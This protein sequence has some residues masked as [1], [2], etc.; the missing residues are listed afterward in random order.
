MLRFKSM[1]S[2]S[3]LHRAAVLA[4]VSLT[5]VA[6]QAFADA[7][8]AE[9][10]SHIFYIMMENHSYAEIV[11][12]QAP[13]ITSLANKYNVATQYYGVTHPSLPNYLAAVS[14]DNQGIWDDCK[15]GA[16][17]VC[18]PEEF[19]STATLVDPSLF[20]GDA[21]E[22]SP[23][24]NAQFL[25]SSVTPHLFS[26]TTLFDSLEQSGRS[27]K[28]YVQGVPGAD[29]GNALLNV[30]FYPG[31]VADPTSTTG[32]TLVKL[33][34]QKHAPLFY[35]QDVAASP[36]RLSKIVPYEDLNN[37]ANPGAGFLAD[38]KSGHVPAFSFIVPDQCHDMHGLSTAGTHWL[39]T[40]GHPELANCNVD[41]NAIQLGDAFVQSTVKAIQ[42]SK[43]W[44]QG[45]NYIIIV[46]D[47]DDYAGTSGCCGS[48]VG[49][50]A[51]MGGAQV[52]AIVISNFAGPR[53]TASWPANHYT[54]LGAI[55]TLW[56]L[57]CLG[58]SCS[59]YNRV[60]LLPLFY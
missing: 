44:K 9:G 35:F 17:V 43:V 56:D 15:A 14:G 40:N 49:V 42:S 16:T 4:A 45:R 33:Y 1:R 53:V 54:L 57:P 59:L 22:A 7:H 55:E 41:A 47:E 51:V 31:Y 18:N 5:A 3:M 11:N 25:S 29:D 19:V 48:P 52:P 12:G 6:P 23:M 37:A 13:F 34:A 28:T 8:R 27:W 30:E 58:Q 21:T 46:W 38:L 2:S 32:Q 50:S 39:V 10:P 36:A 20:S 60:A 26:A 24:T